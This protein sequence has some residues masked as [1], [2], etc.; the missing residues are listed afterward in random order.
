MT[1]KY[2]SNLISVIVPVYN[3]EKYIRKTINSILA[4]KEVALEIIIV[5]DC[6]TDS[7]A[8][9]VSTY[10]NKHQNI[11]Y[12]RLEKNSGVAVARNKALDLAN[13][14]YVAFCD[15]DDLWHEEKLKKQMEHIEKTGAKICFTAID[16]IDE[17][18]KKIKSKRKIKPKINYKFLLKNTMI[19]TST[20]IVDRNHFGNF[21]MPLRRGGQDYATW[22]MLMRNGEMAY[23]VDEVLVSYRVRGDSL[24]ANKFKSAKQVYNIQR[25][26]EKI[27]CIRAFY[28]TCWFIFNALKKKLF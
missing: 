24:S 17:N 11:M 7:T 26:E 21:K 27:G 15:S 6:S 18:S 16:V 9:T 19:A 13:G 20:V 23:G 4:Q 14:R 28:N 5:D 10:L 8:S 22:L 3:G 12:Q 1:Y 25:V 2:D